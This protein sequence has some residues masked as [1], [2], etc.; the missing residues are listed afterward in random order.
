[1]TRIALKV[2]VDTLDGT[3]TGVPALL[4]L[5]DRHN[6]R[7]TFLFSLGPDHTGRA[8]RRLLRPGFLAKVRRTSVASH[9]GVKTLLYGTLLPGPHIARR[10]G[11]VMRAAAGAGH[12]VGIHSYDHVRW[13]DNVAHKDA[14]WTRREL[15]RAGD[16]FEEVFGNRASVAGAAGWQVNRHALVL[17]EQMGLAYAS[18]VRGVAP[19]YPVMD[20]IRSGCP[21]LPTTLPTVDELLG[22]DGRDAGNVHTS[23]FQ[24]SRRPLPGGHVYT[25]HAELEGRRL[26]DAM[27]RLLA[28]WYEAGDRVGT[29]NDNFQALHDRRLETAAVTWGTVPGRSGLL[30]VQ[31]AAQDGR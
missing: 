10:A 19:F 5:F 15:Q 26:I 13:Q 1:M 22:S 30:A 31:G 7:A 6:V 12:E 11:D 24:A 17:E 4:R 20:G 16:A 14:R 3:R 9:Y 2:D 28:M 21:Q 25:L 27:D 8:V 23:I 18:D 29:L